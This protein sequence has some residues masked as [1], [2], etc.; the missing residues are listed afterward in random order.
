VASLQV[1]PDLGP[2]RTQWDELVLEAWPP[3]VMMRSWWAESASDEDTVFLLVVDGERLLGGTVVDVGRRWG[4]VPVFRSIWSESEST[5]YQ[6]VLARPDDLGIV[7]DRLGR[8]FR[9]HRHGIVDIIGVLPGSRLRTTFPCRVEERPF[10]HVPYVTVPDDFDRYLAGRSRNWRSNYRRNRRR[11][12]EDGYVYRR[13]DVAEASTGLRD[14]H[15]LHRLL[16]DEESAFL[17]YYERFERVATA[18]TER[19]ELS[20]HVI[21]KDGR[22][23]AVNAMVELGRFAHFFQTGRDPNDDHQGAGTVLLARYIEDRCD[24]GVREVDLHRGLFTY[25]LRLTDETRPIV[26]L[27]GGWGWAGRAAVVVEHLPHELRAR[28]VRPRR[29]V[30]WKLDGARKRLRKLRHRA[31]RT[32]QGGSA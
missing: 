9:S 23:V 3:S 1:R 26:R 4:F 5:L 21:E 30:G 11:L 31:T 25:K 18:G 32:I 14:L 13:L 24:D 7:A 17:P 12:D 22:A 28:T 6:D 29:W 19:G 8:W 10:S 27:H 20:F 2:F 15:R 16:L